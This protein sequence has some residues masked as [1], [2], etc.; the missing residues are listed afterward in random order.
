MCL[1]SAP[2]ASE[3]SKPTAATAAALRIHNTRQ[4]KSVKQAAE[5]VS[6]LRRV[7]RGLGVYEF[8]RKLG[9]LAA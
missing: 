6:Q 5:F 3:R 8:D 9:G 4:A 7:G 1:N 2:Q